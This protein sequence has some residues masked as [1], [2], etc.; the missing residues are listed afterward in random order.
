[1]LTNLI[2][3]ILKNLS[4][5][6]GEEITHSLSQ[7]VTDNQHFNQFLNANKLPENE[8]IILT[9]ALLPY[10]EPYFFNEIQEQT[11]ENKAKPNLLFYQ[12]S[13]T[14]ALLP[15]FQ[16]VLIIG[17]PETDWEYLQKAHELME[18]K[19]FKMG[20]LNINPL[21]NNEQKNNL[22]LQLVQVETHYLKQVFNGET[23]EYSLS[24]EF[25]AQKITTSLQW[26]NLVIE[27]DTL[28]QIDDIID[29]N[30][31][32]TTIKKEW[33][34]QK[35]IK[36][37]YTT[38]FYGAS[39]TGKT[40]TATLIGQQLEMDVY[41]IDLSL[42]VSKYIG[43]TEKN[44]SSLFAKAENKNWILFFD[45]ADSLFGTRTSV[46]DSHDRYANQEVSY[47]LQRIED[48]EGIIILA[49]NL[50]G[51]IDKA[52]A[53]R[54]QSMIEFKIP[55]STERELLWRQSFSTSTI[56]EYDF[57]SE[58]AQKYELSGGSIVN[59]VQYA[60]LKAL[61]RNE[62]IIKLADVVKGIARELWKEGKTL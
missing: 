10:I 29:W 2:N 40:L 48:F 12:E 41:R 6:F 45:E 39:G 49:S 11:S 5:H 31:H 7:K 36:P 51:N 26:K 19:L 30:I 46:S 25:P 15:L 50:K 33:G 43:E 14:G 58:I 54:F 37:G 32:Q 18:S 35:I 23:I 47:L 56:F 24:S 34:L 9:V 1:M 61:Q 21:S 17:Y 16:T 52:F 62:N 27:A 57:I 53:R 13:T 8:Q 55:K 60:S 44:L 20:I 28:Q 4:K 22:L 3:K 42:I 59:V 38:L